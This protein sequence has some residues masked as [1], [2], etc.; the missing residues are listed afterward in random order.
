MKLSDFQAKTIQGNDLSLSEY[1]NKVVLVVNVASLCG[2]TP[3]YAGL[4]NLY[5]KYKDR[6]FTILGFPCNQFGKQEPE[7]DGAIADFCEARFKI[8]FPLF[9]KV[10][11]NGPETHPLFAWMKEEAPGILGTKA[12]KWNFTKFL[13]ARDGSVVERFAPNDAPESLGPKIEKYL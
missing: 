5:E 9:S 7:G 10:D 6:G 8:R 4:Q 13:I 12:V 1:S 11:V 3:Q 2:F